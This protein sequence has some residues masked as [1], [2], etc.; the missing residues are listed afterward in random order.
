MLSFIKKTIKQI[1][2]LKEANKKLQRHNDNLEI[3]LRM[4]KGYNFQI[5]K[6]V[7]RLERENSLLQHKLDSPY[8][9]PQ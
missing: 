8:A 1:Q 3:E 4:V 9:P 5:E 6:S 2:Q 7:A